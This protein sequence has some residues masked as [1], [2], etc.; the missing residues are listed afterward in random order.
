MAICKQSVIIS[1][2]KYGKINIIRSILRKLFN[3]VF[4]VIREIP[5]KTTLKIRESVWDISASGK[6][7]EQR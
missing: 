7:S 6:Y 3:I 1:K 5:G 2:V 4:Q